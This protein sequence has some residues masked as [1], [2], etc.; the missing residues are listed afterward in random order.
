MQTQLR[1]G[2]D[3]QGLVDSLD[4]IQGMGFRGIYISGTIM[5]N[6]PW[7]ADQYS[8][9]DLTLM[10]MH[11]G[12]LDMWRTTIDEIH[13][14]GM[15]VMIDNT[16]STLADLIA[17]EGYLNTS[18]PFLLSEHQVLWRNSDRQYLDFKFDNEQYN[19]TCD[20]PAFWDD[21]GYPVGTDVTDEM[22]GCYNSE[23]D[24]VCD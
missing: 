13:A 6:M 12:D 22:K 24:Q 3:L 19:E 17:F 23:F 4:Y 11:F 16:V 20:Y 21:T 5:I 9:L 2:G 18:T 15:Y 10:D 1:H 14:R 8:P 7:E